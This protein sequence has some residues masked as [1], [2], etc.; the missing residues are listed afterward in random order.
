MLKSAA[1]RTTLLR[2]SANRTTLPTRR[3]VLP[4]LTTTSSQHRNSP[5]QH[6]SAAHYSAARPRL[7]R[8]LAAVPPLHVHHQQVRY[9][10]HAKLYFAHKPCTP[11]PPPHRPGLSIAPH[12]LTDETY[13]NL[14]RS[15]AM[16]SWFWMRPGNKFQQVAVDDTKLSEKQKQLLYEG[17]WKDIPVHQA[18][19]MTFVPIDRPTSEEPLAVHSFSFSSKSKLA[20]EGEKEDDIE[21]RND[22][23]PTPTVAKTPL[24]TE[25]TEDEDTGKAFWTAEMLGSMNDPRTRKARKAKL[26]PVKKFKPS[27]DRS[28]KEGDAPA[29]PINALAWIQKETKA[30]EQ[31]KKEKDSPLASDVP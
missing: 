30:W 4:A 20:A 3:R 22:D 21:E 23:E 11:A 10:S 7:S 5:P 29:V 6:A 16:D 8:S 27:F 31:E 15:D 26:Q 14:I 25:E 18:E 13:A 24:N 17:E 9:M 2:H 12:I 1:S 19:Q 28:K